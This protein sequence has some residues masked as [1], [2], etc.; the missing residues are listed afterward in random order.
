MTPKEQFEANADK[1]Y[2]NRYGVPAPIEPNRALII[3]IPSAKVVYEKL[4]VED[5]PPRGHFLTMLAIMGTVFA[6]I[7]GAAFPVILKIIGAVGIY[8][9]VHAAV[10]FLFFKTSD[11]SDYDR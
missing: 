1:A 6:V 10:Y 8:G 3:P 4:I 5:G 11:Y 2:E 7:L 9:C